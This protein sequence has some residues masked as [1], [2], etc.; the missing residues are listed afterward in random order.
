MRW[1]IWK[2]VQLG[3]IKPTIIDK[4]VPNTYK[5]KSAQMETFD[6]EAG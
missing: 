3:L 2:K 1:K 6:V 5:V 4:I